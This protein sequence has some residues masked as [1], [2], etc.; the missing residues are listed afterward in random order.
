MWAGGPEEDYTRLHGRDETE[1]IFI[2]RGRQGRGRTIWEKWQVM[3]KD[4]RENE[5]A[6]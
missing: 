3:I 6:K 5:C 1:G 4:Q 2:L